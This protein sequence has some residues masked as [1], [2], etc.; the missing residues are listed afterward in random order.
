MHSQA[1]SIKSLSETG[2]IQAI[3]SPL[4]VKTLVPSGLKA[5]VTAA[6][7]DF[8]TVGTEGYDVDVTEEL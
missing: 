2:Q 7:Q 8:G 4:P 1:C 6:R 5:I 3:L